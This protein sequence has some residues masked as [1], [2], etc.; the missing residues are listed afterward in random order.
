[1]LRLASASRRLLCAV[2]CVW[3]R[4]AVKQLPRGTEAFLLATRKELGSRDHLLQISC[5]P[6]ASHG[7]PR[8]SSLPASHCSSR[9]EE[10][11]VRRHGSAAAGTHLISLRLSEFRDAPAPEALCDAHC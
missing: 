2:P 7:R 6:A 9:Q 8:S 1:M 10:L 5:D 11:A 4:T 3:R